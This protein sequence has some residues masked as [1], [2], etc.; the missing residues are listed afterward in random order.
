[1][2]GKKRH[3]QNRKD[4]NQ[5]GRKKKKSRQYRNLFTP[6]VLRYLALV[7]G[8]LAVSWILHNYLSIDLRE[9]HFVLLMAAGFLSLRLATCLVNFSRYERFKKENH[10][11]ALSE[12]KYLEKLDEF[13]KKHNRAQYE[14]DRRY[15]R[16]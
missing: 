8:L 11:K 16:R 13:Y 4:N 14:W 12:K 3:K 5:D 6:Y 7:L 10:G 9:L 2:K 1:M 15:G